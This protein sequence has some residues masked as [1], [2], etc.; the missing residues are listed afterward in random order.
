MQFPGIYILGFFLALIL[1]VGATW[2]VR[3]M[4][5]RFQIVD[6]SK[7]NRK[8]HK[9]TVPLM[10]GVALFVSVSLSIIGFIFFSD[11]LEIHIPVR[12]YVGLFIAGVC[13]MIGGFLDDRYN[14]K[15]LAQ[16][17]WPALATLVVIGTGIGVQKVTNPLGGVL[18]LG[19]WSFVFTFVWLMGMMYTTKLL[20][21]LDGLVSGMSVIGS[22]MIFFLANTEKFFQSDV[23]LLASMMAGAFVGFLFFNMHPARIFLG[24]GGSLLAGFFLGILAIISGGK[25][26]T[27]LLVMG[28]PILDVAWVMIRRMVSQKSVARADAGHLHHRFLRAGFSQRQT[29]LILWSIAIG[30]GMLT[31]FLQSKEKLIALGALFFLMLIIGVWLAKKESIS[32]GKNTP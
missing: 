18:L 4:A 13:L 28:I 7:E 12:H 26:A 8:I 24:E 25:I 9:K 23:A 32:H 22:A 10:G 29:V 14:Q 19:S 3:R 17:L 21:G 2:V 16:M 6:Y 31:L 11:V 15:P 27:A 20:D 5:I 30:F 1:S